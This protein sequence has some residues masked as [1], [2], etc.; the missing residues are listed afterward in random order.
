MSEHRVPV[1]NGKYTFVARGGWKLDVL[2]HGEPWV[3][4]LNASNAIGSIPCG[5]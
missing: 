2:R 1:A 4:D 5:G 3:E